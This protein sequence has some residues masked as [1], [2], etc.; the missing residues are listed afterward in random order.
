M[1]MVGA[2]T[3]FD[4]P[5]CTISPS[6][7]DSSISVVLPYKLVTPHVKVQ[8]FKSISCN[9][10]ERYD[11]IMGYFRAFGGVLYLTLPPTWTPTGLVVAI[12]GP[13]VVGGAPGGERI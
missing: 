13:V 5:A 8:I 1:V 2:H 10:G 11:P 9:N 12:V 3:L 7:V 6:G 4:P